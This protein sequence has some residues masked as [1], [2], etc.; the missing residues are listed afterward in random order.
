[1]LRGMYFFSCL[2]NFFF[3]LLSDFLIFFFD[4]F[5]WLSG[6]WCMYGWAG[7]LKLR[8]CSA[9]RAGAG[10][11]SFPQMDIHL[12]VR[13]RSALD[14]IHLSRPMRFSWGWFGRR[15]GV[16][17]GNQPLVVY[18]HLDREASYFVRRLN[19]LQHTAP[20]LLKTWMAPK[21]VARATAA[22]M[23]E[24][25]APFPTWLVVKDIDERAGLYR[26]TSLFCMDFPSQ[27]EIQHRTWHGGCA[28]KIRDE[29][30]ET[31]R[32]KWVGRNIK[33]GSM[34]CGI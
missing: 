13:H 4:D 14:N 2:L 16:H 31:S 8:R 23:T 1:M 22:Y 24:Y 7:V 15:R 25:W 19:N 30:V 5:V 33:R 26:C 12:Y 29:E 18:I 6:H 20:T 28:G 17:M 34:V 27:N 11:G 3:F 9:A 21:F 32:V 10:E